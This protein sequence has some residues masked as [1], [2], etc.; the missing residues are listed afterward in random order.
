MIID[1]I[2]IYST[3]CIYRLN[4][5][6]NTVDLLTSIGTKKLLNTSDLMLLFN[7][8]ERTVRGRRKEGRIK[9]VRK[10]CDRYYYYWEDVIKMMQLKG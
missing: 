9:S 4:G 3:S 6:Q 8:S 5:D 1:T 7:V 2:R 10:V